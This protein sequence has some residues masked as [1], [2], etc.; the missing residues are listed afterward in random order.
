MA[1]S[2]STTAGP[3]RGDDVERLAAIA[4]LEH[5]SDLGQ[6]GEQGAEPGPHERVVVGEQHG[7]VS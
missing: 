5:R 7:A 4:R 1:M 6:P 3:V 2:I